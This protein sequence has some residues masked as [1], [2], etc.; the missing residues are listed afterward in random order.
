M[1][2]YCGGCFVPMIDD[3]YLVKKSFRPMIADQEN[4]NGCV[5][6]AFQLSP[7]LKPGGQNVNIK[8]YIKHS[9]P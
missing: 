3:H 8:H 9:S 1:R 7:F 5:R 2:H 6:F 4:I